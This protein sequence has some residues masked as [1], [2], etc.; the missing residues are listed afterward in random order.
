[1]AAPG[2]APSLTLQVEQAAKAVAPAGVKVLT[3]EQALAIAATQNRDIQKAIEYKNWIQGEYVE[4]RAA[5]LP[6]GTFTTNFGRART[7]TR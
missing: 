3:L 1:M 2:A 7:T 6:Q 4:E 5:A